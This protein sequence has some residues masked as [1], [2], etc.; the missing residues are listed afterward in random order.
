MPTPSPRTA[1]TVHLT[2]ALRGALAREALRQEYAS[3]GLAF[4]KP[5][6]RVFSWER[7]E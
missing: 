3:R 6:L 4:A 2:P 7:P 1:R 5:T